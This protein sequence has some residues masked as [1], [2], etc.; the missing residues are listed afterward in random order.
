MP[1]DIV[2]TTQFKR[3]IKRIKLRGKNLAKLKSLVVLLSDNQPLPLKHK[4]HNLVDNWNGY[5]ECHIEPDWLLIYCV[6]YDKKILELAR[7][8]THS[9]LF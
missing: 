5:K 2:Q 6:Q 9:D 3:D 7:T 8:G 4:D 1:L